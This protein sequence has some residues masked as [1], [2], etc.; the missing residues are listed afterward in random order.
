MVEK[1]QNNNTVKTIQRSLEVPS[2][3]L[4][5]FNSSIMSQIFSFIVICI[6]STNLYDRIK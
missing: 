6:Y 4:P 5:N 2:L 1:K 3:I